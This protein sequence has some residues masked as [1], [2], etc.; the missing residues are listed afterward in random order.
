MTD[1]L[2]KPHAP[3]V[4]RSGPGGARRRSR[5]TRRG[6]AALAVL[7]TGVLVG[8]WFGALRFLDPV[9]VTVD[10]LEGGQTLGAPALQEPI[11]TLAVE[12]A[13]RAGQARVLLDDEP[14][15]GLAQ[16]E[17]GGD[18]IIPIRL[19]DLAEGE[20][21]LR[22]ELDR[23]GPLPMLRRSTSFTVDTTP[24]TA[25]VLAPDAPVPVGEP[26]DVRVRVDGA[27]TVQIA[28][29][30]VTIDEEGVA[31]TTL[32]E[33][34]DAA[35]AVLATDDVGNRT[36][37]TV[38]VE[39]ALPGTEGGPPIRAVHM[40]AAAWQADFLRE[41]V[42]Q[43]IDEGRINTVQLDLKDEAGLIGWESDVE[44]AQQ[45]GSTGDFYDLE[46][47]VDQLHDKGVRVIGR[48]VLFRDNNFVEWAQ[49][50]GRMDLLIQ[51]PS[52]GM[53]TKYGGFMNYA[54]QEVLDYNFAIAREAAAAGVDDILL[55]YVRRPDGDRDGQVVPGLEGS[56]EDAIV[57]VVRQARAVT[58][59]SGAELGL[60]V[61]GIS[62]GS[63]QDVSQDIPR[64][65]QH[66]HYVAPM[67]Y[68]SHWYGGGYYGVSDPNGQPFEI[69][70]RSI[71]DFQDKMQGTDAEI[72]PWLQ[73]FDYPVPYTPDMV[74]AQI[75]G[76]AAA[77]VDS[78]MMWDAACTYTTEVYTPQDA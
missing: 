78:F 46:Q 27:E 6:W 73:D 76:A 45:I 8:A 74:T 1:T 71:E 70:Q 33:P 68:P 36:E 61:Y 69:I 24:P 2:V 66:A 75:E 22:V 7:A 53:Y 15:T 25:Q 28:G 29:E 21:T 35:V 10:G 44:L 18:G 63:P 13:A 42:M 41:P 5:L 40:S 62:A 72:V 38:A 47:V 57:E 50:N 14:L 16:A 17:G 77:G 59:E 4:D 31:A 58:D 55:D 23:R 12:P 39:L 20:H 26:V 64:M 60:S 19:P 37:Q 11:A 54:S 34:P 65:A 9:T 43:M 51:T 56:P 49:A 32:P 30:Q 67:L 3:R 48:L 52:G